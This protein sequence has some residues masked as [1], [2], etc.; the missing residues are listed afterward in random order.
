MFDIYSNM[1]LKSLIKDI[2]TEKV[3]T[4]KKLIL[5][6]MTMLTEQMKQMMEEK[7]SIP[8]IPLTQK[9]RDKMMEEIREEYKNKPPVTAQ[10]LLEKIKQW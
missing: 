5:E 6:H 3:E 10:E 1:K 2:I 8:N 4:K 7:Y 9:Q